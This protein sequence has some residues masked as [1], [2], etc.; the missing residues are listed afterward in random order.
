MARSLKSKTSE[1]GSNSAGMIDAAALAAFV[2]R[3]AALMQDRKT[4]DLDITEVLNEAKDAGFA[5]KHMRQLAREQLMDA[6]ELE[7]LAADQELLDRLRHALGG[8]TPLG[9]V[10]LKDV[11]DAAIRNL[12]RSR[13]V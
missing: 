12:T 9:D 11:S 7:V 6:A 3:T 10:A 13:A 2:S 1:T 5:K 8:G 4:I